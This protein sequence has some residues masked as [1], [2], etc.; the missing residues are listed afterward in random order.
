VGRSLEQVAVQLAAVELGLRQTPSGNTI[1][2][3]ATRGLGTK[4][5]P[6]QLR[7]LTSINSPD[8]HLVNRGVNGTLQERTIT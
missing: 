7:R 4:T 6:E 1:V 3:A 8:I 2:S 5:V